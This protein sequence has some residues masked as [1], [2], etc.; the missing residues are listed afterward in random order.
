MHHETVLKE[1]IDRVDVTDLGIVTMYV[2]QEYDLVDMNDPG[3]NLSVQCWHQIYCEVGA[4]V[5]S[6]RIIQLQRHGQVA[7]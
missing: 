6:V 2:S 5:Y 3:D 4:H 1:F 7:C